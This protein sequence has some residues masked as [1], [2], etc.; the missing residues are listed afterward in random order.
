M[1]VCGIFLY[2]SLTSCRLPKSYV[3][4]IATLANLDRRVVHTLQ[5]LREGKWSYIRGST[6]HSSVLTGLSRELGYNTSWGDPALLPAYGGALADAAWKSLGVNNR[7][8]VG[9]IPCEI[10]HGSTGSGFGLQGSCTANSLIRGV[11]A[12]LEAIVIYLPVRSDPPI[13]SLLQLTSA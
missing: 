6:D 4:W 1:C 10:V 2:N 12:F 8:G 13:S 3:K 9:G 11:L 7:A 5:L